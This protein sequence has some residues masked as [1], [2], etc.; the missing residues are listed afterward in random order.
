MEHFKAQEFLFLSS[1]ENPA[2]F[3]LPID[4]GVGFNYITVTSACI[5]KTYYVLPKAATVTVQQGANTFTVTLAKGNYNVLSFQP[6]FAAAINAAG[7]A[8]FVYSVTFPNSSI[9]VQTSKF[10]F[11]VANNGGVQPTFT[12]NDYFLARAMGFKQGQTYSFQNNQLES[13]NVVNFQSYDE[14]MV[15]CDMVEN[16]RGLLQELF[17]A[18]NPYNSSIAWVNSNLALNVKRLSP[19]FSNVTTISLLT[20][21]GDLI[22]FNGS[23]WSLAILIVKCDDMHETIKKSIA[24]NLM[25]DQN[26]NLF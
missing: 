4:T 17:S 5:P 6:L 8:P 14:V 13:A 10:T 7:A 1:T 2:N 19:L 22:D 25:E 16:E 26:K 18:G 20:E 23:E 15:N 21:N 9:E 24:V 11:R 3:V 12:V